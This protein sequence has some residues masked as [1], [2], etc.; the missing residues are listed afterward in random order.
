MQHLH[1]ETVAAFSERVFK[2]ALDGRGTCQSYASKTKESI[3]EV[4]G[5]VRVAERQL[6]NA[7]MS[8]GDSSGR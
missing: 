3:K 7:W 5:T 6:K 8:T 2:A 4:A 1:L